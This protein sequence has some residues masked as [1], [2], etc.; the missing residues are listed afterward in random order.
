[1]PSSPATRKNPRASSPSVTPVYPPP[2][3]TRTR[4]PRTQL[5]AAANRS[6]SAGPSSTPS[7]SRVSRPISSIQSA[8]QRNQPP[9]LASPPHRSPAATKWPCASNSSGKLSWFRLIPTPITAYR[10]IAL[11]PTSTA[12]STRIPPHFFSFNSRSFGHRIS[13]RNPVTVCNRRLRRQPRGQRQPKRHRHRQRHASPARSHTVH[14]SPLSATGAHRVPAPPSAHPRPNT[15]PAAPAC[16]ASSASAFVDPTEGKCR[17]LP[18]NCVPARC[19]TCTALKSKMRSESSAWT[20]PLLP[21][22]THP[23]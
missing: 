8:Q 18:A 12:V 3:S 13:T 19:P 20:T 7:Y 1:M 14:R 21:V 11:T 10:S 17:T 23:P 16:A 22:N 9:P 5:E 4:L 6:S 15:P 2:S